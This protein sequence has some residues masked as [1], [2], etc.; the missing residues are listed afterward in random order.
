MVER[1]EPLYYY[2][3]LWKDWRSNRRVQ[4][5]HYVA[6]GFYRELLDEQFIEGSIPK[7]IVALAEICGCPIA[8]MK[9]YWPEIEPHFEDDG[10]GGLI[11]P[12]ME[13]MRTE[14]DATRAKQSRAGKA[15]AQSKLLNSKANPTH[16]QQMLTGLDGGQPVRDRVRVRD[17]V[18][19]ESETAMPKVVTF[20]LPEWVDR[21]AWDG[22][23]EM[24]KK[25]RAPL[26]DQ[27]RK[28]ALATLEKLRMAGHNP[29]MV[30]DQSVM[31]CWKGL[32]EL[33]GNFTNG[34]SN[35]N[36]NYRTKSDTTL[37]ALQRSIQK[38]RDQNGAGEAG[39]APPGDDRG[40]GVR[41]LH[42]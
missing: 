10:Q 17:I 35:G 11:H 33:R 36:G 24:R 2:K 18:R 6:R 37:S 13:T 34:G 31:N 29:A 32:F 14:M 7:D 27:A 19:E 25:Q 12:K 38:G 8:V 39:G 40:S 5:M 16:V 20:V 23:E 3:W 22:F 21:D 30:L 9:E 42:G 28:L 1:L 26:T 15:S 4:R 41:R